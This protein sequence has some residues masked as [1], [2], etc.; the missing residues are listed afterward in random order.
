MFI[1]HYLEINGPGEYIIITEDEDF[2]VKSH[3]K[4]GYKWKS[5]H[6][7]EGDDPGSLPL[8]RALSPD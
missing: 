4:P 3:T 7:F 5:C 8:D 2:A 6:K 1:H